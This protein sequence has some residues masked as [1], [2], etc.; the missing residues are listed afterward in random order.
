MRKT[1]HNYEDFEIRIQ[2]EYLNLRCQMGYLIA[3]YWLRNLIQTRQLLGII[4]Y[5]A[6]ANVVHGF[7]IESLREHKLI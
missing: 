6:I 3:G 4:G 2:E 7:M 5:V 1:A